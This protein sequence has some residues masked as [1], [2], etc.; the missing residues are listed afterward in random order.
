M[1]NLKKGKIFWSYN[2]KEVIRLKVTSNFG[3]KIILSHIHKLG[4]NNIVV[5]KRMINEGMV[6][7]CET[8]K[9]AQKLFDI[10]KVTN[11]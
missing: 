8:Y 10:S 4:A 5:D 3:N 2:D 1:K 9:E 7:L 6:I 11:S